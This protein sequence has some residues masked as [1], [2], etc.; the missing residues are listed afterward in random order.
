MNASRICDIKLDGYEVLVVDDD[1]ASCLVIS[2]MLTR[3]GARVQTA[4]SGPRA[5]ALFG[6]GRYPVVVTDICMP[7]MDG[8]ELA[9]KLRERDQ[10]VMVIAASAVSDRERL[11]SAIQLGFNDYILKPVHVEKLAWA[12]KRCCETL[13]ARQRLKDEQ[14]K[15]RSVLE[16][17]GEGVS[18]KN[19][20]LAVVYQNRALTELL[21]DRTG[22]LCYTAYDGSSAPCPDCQALLAMQRGGI[23]S[24]RKGFLCHGEE[25]ILESTASPLTDAR[26]KIVGVVEITRDVSEQVR[27]RRILSNI[28]KGVSAKIGAEFFTSLVR[29]LTEALG[30]SYALVGELNEAGDRITTLAYCCQGSIRDGFAYPLADTPCA[31]VL[32]NGS[33]IYPDH[34]ADRF[35]GDR[36]L[37]VL[38]IESYCGAALTDS[39]GRVFG[40]LCTFDPK[41]IIRPEVVSDIISIF[42]SRASAE[43]ERVGTEK[44]LRSHALQDPLTGLANRRMFQERLGSAI[45]SARRSGTRFALLYLD[46]D[47]FKEI[48]DRFGHDAGDQVLVQA[49]ERIRG[50]FRR[51]TDTISRHGGDEFAV[52][53]LDCGERQDLVTRADR[54][55]ERFAPPLSIN[56]AEVRVTASI[57]ISVYPDDGEEAKAL[58]TA[59]DRAMYQAKQA[60]RN[61]YRFANV[62][63]EP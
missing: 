55:I 22:Q 33:G 19:L 23:H 52:I 30:M 47:H 62:N 17:L 27:Q 26:G 41:P 35:P 16:C 14:S 53:L 9:A 49:A 42:A 13:E 4:H 61:T 6:Q 8:M 56:G 25:L 43:L 10:E 28:A 31:E 40:V 24:T 20:D 5:L 54:L 15:F 36:S 58:E 39:S 50:C 11:L 29:Y 12:V 32:A 51:E 38:G 34:A 45:A 7:G 44:I 21:G 57:G 18:L 1:A 3:F 2:K 46:L 60:N 63:T 59:A 37:R 48:N